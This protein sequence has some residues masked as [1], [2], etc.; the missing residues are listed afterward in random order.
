MY[1][2]ILFIFYT[3]TYKELQVPDNLRKRKSPE[4]ETKQQAHKVNL[5][6]VPT[7]ILFTEIAT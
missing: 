2:H 3:T 1:I 4:K 7:I 6:N 5:K